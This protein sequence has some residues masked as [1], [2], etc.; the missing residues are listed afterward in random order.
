VK[1]VHLVGFIIKE[2]S[3]SSGRLFN[4]NKMKTDVSGYC[5]KCE[6]IAHGTMQYSYC[7]LAESPV[8]RISIQLKIERDCNRT[9]F[10]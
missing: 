6:C 1:L 9:V 5:M 2:P 7:F 3:L 10:V 8:E 4:H